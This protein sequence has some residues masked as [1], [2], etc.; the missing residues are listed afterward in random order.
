MHGIQ[1]WVALPDKDEETEPNFSHHPA[2]DL[3]VMEDAG[4]SPG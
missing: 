2:S 4:V 1:S 3:P